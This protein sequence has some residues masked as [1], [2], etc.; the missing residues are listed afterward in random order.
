MPRK[1]SRLLRVLLVAALALA[2][3]PHVARAAWPHDPYVNVPLCTATGN[4]LTPVLVSDGA[5]GAIVA[6]YDG[7]SGTNDIYV[8]RVSAGGAAQ[9]SANGVALCTAANNQFNPTIVT[10]GAS[11][12]VVAWYD[13]RSG[14]DDIY[15]QRVSAAGAAQWTSNGVALCTAANDQWDPTIVSDGSGG[16]IVTWVDDRSGTNYDIYAR[17]VNAAGTAQWPADG[18]AL[19]MA[20]NNQYAPAIVSDGAGGAIVTWYDFRSGTDYDIYAQRVSATGVKLWAANGVALCTA[21]GSQYNPAIASDGAGGAIVAWRDYRSGTDFDIY[22]QRVSAAGATQWTA[23]GVALCASTNSQYAPA[24][25]SDGSGGAIVTWYD[26][27][28]GSNYDIYTQRVSVAGVTQWTANGV[29]LCTS[30]DDQDIPRIAPDGTGGA[31]VAWRDYRSGTNYDI[32]TQRVSATGVTQWTANGVALSSAAGVQNSPAIVS[33]GSGGAIVTWYDGRG[34]DDDIYAQRIERFGRLGNPEATI[35][36]VRDVANDQG[37]NVKVSWAASYLDADPTYGIYEYRLWRSAP[38]AALLGR[39]RLAGAITH[40]PDE[41]AASGRWLVLP[42]AATDYA[43]EL[44]GSQSAAIL[45]SYSLVA[46]T[47]G[48]SVGGSNPRTAFMVEARA[49]SSYASDRW[50]SAPDSGYSVDNLS[51]GTPAPFTGA[52][53]NGSS[54][55]L[56]GQSGEP[57]FASY[58]LYRGS[59]AGFV[60]GPGN[61]V[62]MLT[63]TGYAD[64]AG[65]PYYY[66]LS[67]VDVHGNESGFALVQPAGTVDVPGSGVPRELWLARATPNPMR[68]AATLRFGLPRAGRVSLAVFD[69]QGR[70]VRSLRDGALE[71]GEHAVRWDG[72]DEG[73]RAVASGLYFV[74]L[75]A[76]GRTLTQRLA[77]VR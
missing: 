29:A 41:A 5:G 3:T 51:P 68:D 66:K 12:A 56:W 23:D 71:A 35:A 42:F 15:V 25:V 20:G 24:I 55:L 36:S 8:Q 26:F 63:G 62:A 64:A 53:S 1:P 9:W 16:A 31:I 61:L 11:G 57:D 21:A 28:S 52:Y 18:V 13:G 33:D 76:A 72:R 34:T 60:P 17:R 49:G 47:T 2:L 50:F 22:A 54:V 27:R 69:Q 14:T 43:W 38:Q 58:R 4:Q 6:W 48:D 45:A 65:E 39:E 75:E 73:G 70:R 30:A 37:G 19:C 67:A 74:R 32:Y 44:V 46:A 59:S 40:D 77:A 7:R 10:D